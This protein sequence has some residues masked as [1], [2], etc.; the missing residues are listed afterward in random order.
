MSLSNWAPS[1][2]MSE[3]EQKTSAAMS[4]LYA[5]AN[6][7]ERRERM[8]TET[9]EWHIFKVKRKEG[10]LLWINEYTT[11]RFYLDLMTVAFEKSE[12]ALIFQMWY[13]K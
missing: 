8:I 13:V 10:L 3:I 9:K 12:D 2:P 4:A 7:R 11:G 5:V 1:V 6:T